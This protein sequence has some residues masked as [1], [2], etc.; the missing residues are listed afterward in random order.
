MI[1]FNIKYLDVSP[2][3]VIATCQD[4]YFHTHTH[5]HTNEREQFSQP[6]RKAPE[7]RL[8][9]VVVVV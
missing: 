7:N 3:D 9:V 5:T 2:C 4:E 8:V 1:R 6:N